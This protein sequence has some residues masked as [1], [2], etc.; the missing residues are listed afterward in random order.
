MVKMKLRKSQDYYGRWVVEE[1]VNPGI[2]YS[3]FGLNTTGEDMWLPIGEY[4][5]EEQADAVIAEI[6]KLCE[7]KPQYE[8]FNAGANTPG[9]DGE[10]SNP[11]GMLTEE[12]DNQNTQIY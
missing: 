10:V 9:E 4:V 3:K 1:M 6:Q 5:S 8:F 12:D 7:F 11:F 2:D